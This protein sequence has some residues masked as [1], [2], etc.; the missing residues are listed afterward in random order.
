[1]I[2]KTK[3]KLAYIYSLSILFIK[4]NYFLSGFDT[5]TIEF[6]EELKKFDIVLSS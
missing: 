2:H 4:A 3:F 6:C 1:M 5:S